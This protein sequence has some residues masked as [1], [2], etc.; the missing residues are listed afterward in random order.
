MT[1]AQRVIKYLAIA[2]AIILIAL[3]IS[4]IVSTA[5]RIIGFFAPDTGN[6]ETAVYDFAGEDIRALEIDVEAAELTV[7]VGETLYV[8]CTSSRVNVKLVGS[9]LTV[10]EEEAFFHKTDAYKLNVTLPDV[11]LTEADI[12][13]GAG[14][15]T[16]KGLS[17]ERLELDLGAGESDISGLT[18]S[19]SA[20]VDG[21]AGRISIKESLITSLE[22][23][24]GIGEV[25]I[26][27]ALSGDNDLDCGVGDLD[28]EL[29]GVKDSYSVRASKGIGSFT[30]NGSSV[31]DGETL[32]SGD[33]KV[34]IDSGVGSVRVT[35]VEQLDEN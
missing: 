23:D 32:G 20:D 8:E 1:T 26:S 14:K 5:T 7:S 15:L 10:V 16:L 9:T 17:T 31:S 34:N 27:A 18:V 24:M 3:I 25:D 28:L 29:I 22:F 4:G 12:S 6:G 21:G 35:L 30:V 11:M 13:T 19:R 33:I 2:L